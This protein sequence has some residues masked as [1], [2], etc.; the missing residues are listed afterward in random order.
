MNS[1]T[2]NK[3]LGACLPCYHKN[4]KVQ[5]VLKSYHNNKKNTKSL[6][7]ILFEFHIILRIQLK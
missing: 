7:K 5:K 2:S 1:M 6:K 4:K 3:F